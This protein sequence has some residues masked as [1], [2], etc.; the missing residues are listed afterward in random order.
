MRT[1]AARDA[2]I[3]LVL[4]T[5]LLAPLESRAEDSATWL[6]DR[7]TGV[8][9][10]MFGTY[11]RRGELLVYPFFEY[12]KDR[13]FEYKPAEM[14][15]GLEEDYRGT[16]EA[17]EGLLFLGYGVTD[18]LALELEASVIDARFEKAAD[19]PSPTPAVIE[20]S[21]VGDVEGQ[22]R[23]RWMRETARRP[24]LFTYSEAVSPQ[25]EDK[26][27]IGTPDWELKQGIGLI[28]GFAWGTMT[29]RVA[30][31]YLVEDSSFDSGEYA[32]EYLKRISP[33]WL[34]YTGVEGVQDELA[35][36]AEAQYRMADWA[37]LKLN[38][39]LGV[40]SKAVDWAPEV[41]VVFS[42]PVGRP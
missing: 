32:V 4:G 36:I 40:T 26:L 3:A 24:E 30:A 42:I 15:F 37:T 39:A 2:I 31:E 28:K 23:I 38:N 21:G 11:V 18:W 6:S 5:S 25:Q 35:W 8:P 13:D 33:R 29:V 7:G 41:G 22:V 1:P 10:S 20:E 9:T 14:G 12:Y 34:F 17:S 27:L 16:F 19:D